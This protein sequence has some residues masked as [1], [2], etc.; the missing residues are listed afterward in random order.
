V[1]GE[2]FE[3]FA[4]TPSEKLQSMLLA[5]LRNPYPK[6]LYLG[7]RDQSRVFTQ[8]VYNERLT[9]EA[10]LQMDLSELGHLRVVDMSGP[11]VTD[12]GFTHIA[13]NSLVS[14]L[15]CRNAMVTDSGLAALEKN[16]R[17]GPV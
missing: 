14:N 9:D 8:Q 2:V 3:P 7:P 5:V 17:L 1:Q 10:I 11:H 12:R 13:G 16:T 15:D 4:T 6:D